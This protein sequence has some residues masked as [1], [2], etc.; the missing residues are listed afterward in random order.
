MSKLGIAPKCAGRKSLVSVLLVA[1]SLSFAILWG[2]RLWVPTH[3]LHLGNWRIA[4]GELLGEEG[5]PDL[6]EVDLCFGDA[7]TAGYQIQIYDGE[8]G[9]LKTSNWK[10]TDRK[11][12]C[13]ATFDRPKEWLHLERCGFELSAY[14]QT[15]TDDADQKDVLA[16][17]IRLSRFV[18]GLGMI[19]AAWFGFL[20]ARPANHRK[21]G[22]LVGRNQT[23]HLLD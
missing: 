19:D 2:C 9:V 22:F 20:A 17:R 1:L 16:L 15:T 11:I 10:R 7:N 12:P 23:S 6:S 13:D 21:R 18:M 4:R 5:L 8:F 14:H 3:G